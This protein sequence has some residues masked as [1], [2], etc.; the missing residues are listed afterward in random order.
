MAAPPRF[1]AVYQQDRPAWMRG[2]TLDAALLEGDEDLE[3][4]GE[5]HRQA[6]LW[7]V[8]GGR[9]RPEERVRMEVHALLLAEDGNPYDSNAVSVLISGLM[10]GHLPRDQARIFRPGL[11]A[12]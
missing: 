8:V 12:A 4:V 1:R 2:D 7:R 9:R 11:V 3:L 6:N 10:V 5:S